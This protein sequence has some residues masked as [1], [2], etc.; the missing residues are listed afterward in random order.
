LSEEQ[1]LT[2]Q[3]SKVVLCRYFPML[4]RSITRE[5]HNK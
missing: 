1:I 2:S 3:A 4:K 5:T